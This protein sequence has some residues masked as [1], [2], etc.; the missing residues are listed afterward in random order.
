MAT[1]TAEGSRS[2]TVERNLRWGSWL[3]GL[4]RLGFIGYAVI[5]L[6]RNFTDAFLEPDFGPRQVN[7]GKERSRTSVRP[8]I[9][10]SGTSTS[11]SRGSSR[12]RA[13]QSC[14]S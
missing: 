2:A 8:C 9:T 14:S 7:V 1:I 3:M 10:T 5:F 13:W 4:R 11:R 12:P 6:I